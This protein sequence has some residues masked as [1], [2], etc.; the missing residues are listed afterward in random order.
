MA[1][2]PPDSQA[3]TASQ[4]APSS[5]G[6]T[7]VPGLAPT[8]NTE[9]RAGATISFL[10]GHRPVS[11]PLTVDT[12]KVTSCVPVVPGIS[13]TWRLMFIVGSWMRYAR[14][15]SGIRAVM[16]SIRIRVTTIFMPS[17]TG[18][19]AGGTTLSPCSSGAPAAASNRPTFGAASRRSLATPPS[20]IC[21]FFALTS[22]SAM[23]ANGNRLNRDAAA[24]A[25]LRIDSCLR[26][27]STVKAV[28][29]GEAVFPHHVDHPR[30]HRRHRH[31]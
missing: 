21:T 1:Q 13:T 25:T 9:G 3:L 30:L 5:T 31:R 14:G 15:G 4:V 12:T 6:G 29:D 11:T 27:S 20:T 23:P 7:Y 26:A 19:D 17:V 16:S 18:V 24:G 22:D 10:T 8:R 2:L 28:V